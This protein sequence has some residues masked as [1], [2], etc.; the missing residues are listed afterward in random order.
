MITNRFFIGH[1]TYLHILLVDRNSVIALFVIDW[2]KTAAAVSTKPLNSMDTH[3]CG[4]YQQYP[5]DCRKRRYG[6]GKSYILSYAKIVGYGRPDFF[7]IK[8]E[9]EVTRGQF[10]QMMDDWLERRGGKVSAGWS[11]CVTAD[12][13]LGKK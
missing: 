4:K 12:W 2:P 8:E 7:I 11:P 1:L 6:T 3:H 9:A 5:G 10:D 13:L